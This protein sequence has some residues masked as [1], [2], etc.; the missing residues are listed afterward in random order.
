MSL[1]ENLIKVFAGAAGKISDAVQDFNDGILPEWS[2]TA[3]AT[4]LIIK[5]G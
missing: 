2:I 1:A 3:H 5:V 4:A